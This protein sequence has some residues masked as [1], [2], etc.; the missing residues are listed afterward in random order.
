[1]LGD[2]VAG[3]SHV[4][5]TGSTARF[6]SFVNIR[7]FQEV[8]PF[9]DAKQGFV[10]DVGPAAARMARAEGVEA[11]ARAVES[12]YDETS[13][14]TGTADRQL[15]AV[16]AQQRSEDLEV[17]PGAYHQTGPE[18]PFLLL[19]DLR[20]PRQRHVE[21]APAASDSMPGNGDLHTVTTVA[22]F[23]HGQEV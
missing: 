11:H 2:Y 21:E 16:P 10:A 18:T 23:G 7:D 5:P 12:R 4:M 9:L 14:R 19:H 3:P 1:A 6:A 8:I 22:Q 17:H 15:G 13:G 20:D